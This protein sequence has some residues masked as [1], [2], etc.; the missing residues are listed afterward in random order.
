MRLIFSFISFVLALSVLLS[1]QFT[2]SAKPRV[3]KEYEGVTSYY[4]GSLS[5]RKTASGEKYRHMGG[6]TA[7]HRN[8]PFGT[9]LLVTD[10]DTG[11]SVIVKVND[12]GPF[13]KGRVLDLSGLAARRLGIVK[14]GICKVHIRVLSL[15]PPK[16]SKDT[17][18]DFI[19]Q[20]NNFNYDEQ[21]TLTL[22]GK[23]HVH[24]QT[25]KSI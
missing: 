19:H 5:G 11:K 24:H 6:M 22:Q 15:P 8:M 2:H 14:K 21:I 16:K 23:R 7:A 10:L 9:K 13:V 1:C 25:T 20:Q 17:L 18:G 12:R 3:G 4:H